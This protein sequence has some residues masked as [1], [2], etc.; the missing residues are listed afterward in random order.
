M[1]YTYT[2]SKGPIVA[3]VPQYNQYGSFYKVFYENG[4]TE[5]S[6]N[7]ITFILKQYLSH[8]RISCANFAERATSSRPNSLTVTEF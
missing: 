4:E 1:N 8:W 3:I 2:S 6:Q 5:E 7:Q